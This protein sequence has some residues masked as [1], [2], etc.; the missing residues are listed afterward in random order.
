VCVRVCVCVC[1]CLCVCVRVCV[2][3]CARVL[4]T[5]DRIPHLSGVQDKHREA[6]P[7]L[8]N[9]Q[10]GTNAPKCVRQQPLASCGACSIILATYM[11][12]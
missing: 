5:L 11:D 7:S 3:L 12:V 2:C 1:V 6:E 10:W 4:L 9:A 8:L